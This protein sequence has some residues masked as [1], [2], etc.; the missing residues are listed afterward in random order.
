MLEATRQVSL[1][2]I[3]GRTIMLAMGITKRLEAVTGEA[4]VVVTGEDSA[5]VVT[6]EGSAVAM[7]AAAGIADRRR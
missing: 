3:P 2:T 6:G 1:S 5:A 4:S 7:A